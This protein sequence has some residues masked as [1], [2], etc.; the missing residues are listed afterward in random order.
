MAQDE[1]VIDIQTWTTRS[2]R[3]NAL[4]YGLPDS[5]Y[6]NYYTLPARLCHTKE[7]TYAEENHVHDACCNCG[8]IR[9][10]RIC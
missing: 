6:F 7:V 2:A 9:K 5:I 8:V 3:I 1:G 4:T 10:C